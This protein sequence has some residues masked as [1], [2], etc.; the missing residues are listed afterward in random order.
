[1]KLAR[2]FKEF[3]ERG[4]VIDL[5]IA[6]VMGGA[7]NTIISSLVNDVIMPTLSLLTFGYDFTALAIQ[8]GTG[9]HAAQ[10]TY[11]N[12]IA[13]IIHF[14]LIALVIFLLIKGYNH[15]TNKSIGIKPATKSCPYC[16][17]PINEA[18]TRCP[19][20]TTVLDPDAVPEELR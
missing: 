4:N 8:I 12:L 10:L 5:A 3:I 18:A 20:C 15:L 7:F 1:M 16:H 6:V 14:V 11:G 19:N 13:A 9:D 17:S 2:E